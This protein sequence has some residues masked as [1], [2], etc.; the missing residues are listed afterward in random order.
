MCGRYSI[1]FQSLKDIEDYYRAKL[2]RAFTWQ[3]H[4]NAAPRQDLPVVIGKDD[5]QLLLLMNWSLVPHWWARPLKELDK[6]SRINAR[7][8]GVA[9]SRIF[10]NAYQKSQRCI[11]PM[12]SFYEWQTI[13]GQKTKKP[14]RILVADKDEHPVLS[15]AGL[16]DSWQSGDGKIKLNSFTI[17][18]TEANPLL[19]KIHNDKERMPVILQTRQAELDW[20]NPH[21]P[22]EAVAKL[23]APAAEGF[24]EAYEISTLVN[25]PKNN[26]A[27]IHQPV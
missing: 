16:W 24:L 3:P 12:D 6:F 8:E 18:T 5:Q 25:T 4:Y 21:H 20:L 17:L 10:Q 13:A 11:V 9:D 26:S 22:P 27:E 7:S 19:A 23:M 15:V 2:M 14:Y 1:G